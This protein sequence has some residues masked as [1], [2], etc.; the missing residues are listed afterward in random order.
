MRLA[1]GALVVKGQHPACFLL[2]DLK[3]PIPLIRSEADECTYCARRAPF[4]CPTSRNHWAS[5]PWR[6]VQAIALFTIFIWTILPKA[7]GREQDEYAKCL[8]SSAF[9]FPMTLDCLMTE[10]AQACDYD[11]QAYGL[12]PAGQEVE[13]AWHTTTRSE[14]F[15]IHA[16]ITSSL[17]SVRYSVVPCTRYPI[18]GICEII[19]PCPISSIYQHVITITIMA[20][21][22]AKAKT[23]RAEAIKGLR[24]EARSKSPSGRLDTPPSYFDGFE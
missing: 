8:G 3:G 4:P 13:E 15:S 22:N 5:S 10:I 21:A 2:T 12:K 18:E 1:T 20:N 16:S 6:H 7:Y 11:Q 19:A 14:G 9:V 24:F 23:S 17:S